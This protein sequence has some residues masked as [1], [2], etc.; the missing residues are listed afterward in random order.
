M[1]ITRIIHAQRQGEHAHRQGE[2]VVK[3]SEKDVNECDHRGAATPQVPSI[4]GRRWA[5]GY[6]AWSGSGEGSD[7]AESMVL[8]GFG[9][10]GPPAVMPD[11]TRRDEAP[12]STPVRGHRAALQV[13]GFPSTCIVR[14]VPATTV[15]AQRPW[16][17]L[18]ALFLTLVMSVSLASC[19]SS[20]A[21]SSVSSTTTRS[22]GTHAT[23][24]TTSVNVAQT[25]CALLSA[26][27]VGAT[28]GVTVGPPHPKVRGAVTTCTYKAEV[29]A[30]SV[31]IE[32]DVDASATTFA[33][34]RS[35]I[36]NHAITNSVPNLGTQ[37]YSFKETSG[38]S[39]VNTVVTLQG[40]LQTIVTGT[41]SLPKVL[42]LS[43]EI[44]YKIDQ[45]NASTTTSAP[46]AS[47]G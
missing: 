32:Y 19:S 5:P 28:M 7:L 9:S 22:T 37:A 42:N 47:T 11:D 31:I 13:A 29:L 36:S 44:L 20:P 12:A 39:T 3:Q 40:T 15:T 43:E 17:V 33:S 25:A 8:A 2:M 30:Q 45:H 6:P 16:T 46:T 14:R 35:S 18:G 34:D 10:T 24:S 41:S 21:G 4:A 38:S 23:T 1:W 26:S 27:E